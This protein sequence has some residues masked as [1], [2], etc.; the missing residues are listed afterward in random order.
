MWLNIVIWIQ[1]S[2]YLSKFTKLKSLCFFACSVTWHNFPIFLFKY[3]L[4]F[5]SICIKVWRQYYWLPFLRC[6][7]HGDDFQI[8]LKLTWPFWRETKWSNQIYWRDSEWRDSGQSGYAVRKEISVPWH[9]NRLA[10]RF[11][12]YWSSN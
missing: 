4:P 3:T 6:I 12:E 1:L 11:M 10:L 2:A 8:S 9:R 5:S 7:E